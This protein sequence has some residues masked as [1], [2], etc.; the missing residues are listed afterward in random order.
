[1]SNSLERIP[2][3]EAWAASYLRDLI[4]IKAISALYRN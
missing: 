1:M 2:N 4:A 3:A